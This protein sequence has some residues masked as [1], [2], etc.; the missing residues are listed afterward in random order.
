MKEF[1][2]K[3][4][5]VGCGG[6]GTYL[7]PVLSKQYPK[8][9]LLFIDGD[10]FEDKNLDRQHFPSEFVGKNKAEAM[11]ILY[12]GEHIASMLNEFTQIEADGDVAALFVCVDNNR[13]RRDC[14]AQGDRLGIPVIVCANEEIES[15][16]YLYDPSMK[17]TQADPRVR[18]PNLMTDPRPTGPACTV[19]VE[20]GPQSALANATAAAFG[21][22]LF[23]AFMNIAPRLTEDGVGHYAIEHNTNGNTMRSTK[24]ISFIALN[25]TTKHLENPHEL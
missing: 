2:G 8:A 12:G 16:A 14:L 13:A 19:V 17:G 25:G 6:V 21:I 18:Y 20:D 24:R 15:Q 23:H 22:N 4:A 7:A 1:Q 11:S 3:I 5:I 9:Q 10:L